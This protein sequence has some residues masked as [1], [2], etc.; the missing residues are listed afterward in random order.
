MFKLSAVSASLLVQILKKV[1]VLGSGFSL[2]DVASGYVFTFL[3]E[4]TW[5]WATTQRAIFDSS[6][7]GKQG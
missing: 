1:F 3:A 6:F 4:F 2:G 5:P 7:F